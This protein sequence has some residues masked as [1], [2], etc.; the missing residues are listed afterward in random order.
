MKI[1]KG[2]PPDYIAVNE[3]LHPLIERLSRLSDQDVK[4]V[5]AFVDYLESGTDHLT[6]AGHNG[7]KDLKLYGFM[8]GGISPDQPDGEISEEQA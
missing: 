8:E 1:H 2:L 6:D 3:E 7:G 4:E 5:A